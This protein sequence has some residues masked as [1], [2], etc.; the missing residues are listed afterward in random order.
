MYLTGF[1]MRFSAQEIATALNGTV[2]GNPNTE[3]TN[4]SKI[5][6]GVPGTL[7]FIANPKYATYILNLKNLFQQLW[8]GLRMH[9]HHLL[10][11]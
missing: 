11:C 9:T 2:E 10:L 4:V 1:C 7:S 6:E 5:E 3:V 8:L